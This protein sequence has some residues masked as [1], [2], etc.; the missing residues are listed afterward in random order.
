MVLSHPDI[1]A[2]GACRRW[3]TSRIR[4]G[5]RCRSGLGCVGLSLLRRSTPL[6]SLS[7]RWSTS[8]TETFPGPT[9]RGRM[10][11]CHPSSLPSSQEG[12]TVRVVS[13]RDSL[14]TPTDRWKCAMRQA[15]SSLVSSI[16][17]QSDARDR[18]SRRERLG[19]GPRQHPP[20]QDRD[21]PPGRLPVHHSH[22][23][24]TRGRRRRRGLHG[25]RQRASEP[26]RRPPPGPC[27]GH[28]TPRRRAVD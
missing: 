13:S 19:R 21:P 2:I 20:W 9:G 23:T 28:S 15:S 14:D 7:A 8:T 5:S 17:V 16:V 26:A 11:S 4:R 27:R 1:D 25:R 10:R 22:G 24:P 18:S 12:D 3:M 6:V